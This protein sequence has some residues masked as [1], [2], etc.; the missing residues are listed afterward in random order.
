MTPVVRTNGRPSVYDRTTAPRGT[1]VRRPPRDP[2]LLA[3]AL[4]APRV[5]TALVVIGIALRLWQYLAGT[6]LWLDEVML[7]RNIVELPF[8]ALLT[9]P[10]ALDQVAPRGFLLVEKLVVLAFGPGELALRAFP[11]VCGLLTV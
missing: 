8:G 1:G 6:S 9:Q 11:A 10:L 4:T 5:L 3:H 2:D 7:S